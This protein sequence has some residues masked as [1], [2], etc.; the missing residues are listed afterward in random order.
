LKEVGWA[1]TYLADPSDL[2]TPLDEDP[3]ALADPLI[4]VYLVSRRPG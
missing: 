3:A 1:D 2:T 4:R